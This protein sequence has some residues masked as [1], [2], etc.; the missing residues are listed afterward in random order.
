[1]QEFL[2]SHS[3]LVSITPLQ[4]LAYGILLIAHLC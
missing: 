4:K 3:H 1:M 2:Y